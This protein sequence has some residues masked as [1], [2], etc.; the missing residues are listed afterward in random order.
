MKK[1]LV[2]GAGLVSRPLVRYLLD[3]PDFFVTVASRTVRKAEELI[4]GHPRGS[5]VSLDV[6]DD[7][8]LEDLVKDHLLSVSLLPYTYHVKVA[9][10]CIKHKKHMVTTSYVS[11]DMAKLD[12]PAKEAGVLI[13]NEIGVDPGIDHMSAM[14]I[15]HMVEKE[16][17]K[18]TSF[19]SYCG[20]LPAPEANDNPFGYKF[21]WSP[22]GVLM[23][24]RNN[25][26][27]LKDGKIIE[28]EGKDLF[29]HHWEMNVEPVGKLEAYPNRDSLPYIET[30]GLEGINSMFRGTFR[31]TGWCK[32][33]KKFADLGMLKDE[34]DNRFAGKTYGEFTAI[35]AGCPNAA[36]VKEE[37][38]AKLGLN[39]DSYIIKAMEWLGLFDDV[40]IPEGTP[41]NPMDILGSLMQEKMQYKEGERDMLVL[42]HI[43]EAD[44]PQSGRKEEITSTMIDYGIPHGSS[45]MSR[46]VSLPA[47]I[48]VRMIL[49]DKIKKTGVVIP[50]DADIYE[51]VLA[52]LENMEITFEE[53]RKEIL[54]K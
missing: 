19:N 1:V 37:T 23:A 33:L 31:N 26:R 41:M 36:S 28:I 42:H 53:K 20:G 9:N 4:C 46:T 18:I 29:D 10:L 52:E 14:K 17:G 8:A 38:A 15:I 34:M 32:I 5:A 16:G 51:P 40:V 12:T 50:V 47:A 7:N 13:L 48:A 6:S 35:L 39:T 25:A 49:T 22:R 21:S 27:Y 11:A 43:F 44:F 30:Y 45:S 2:L 54:V 3:Q 24:G